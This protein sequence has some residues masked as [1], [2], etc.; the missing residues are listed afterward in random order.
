MDGLLVPRNPAVTMPVNFNNRRRFAYPGG[1]LARRVRPRYNLRSARMFTR[2]ARPSM[3]RIRAG[4]GV[5]DHFDR[6]T[7]YRKKLMPRYKKRR[8]IRFVKKV[9][10]V[11]EKTLGT[12]TIVFNN[13][14]TQEIDYFTGGGVND[15]LQ[16]V[17]YACLYGV[18]SASGSSGDGFLGSKDLQSIYTNSTSSNQA[19]LLCFRSAVLDLTFVNRNYGTDGTTAEN[20]NE[21]LEID[22]YEV[23]VRKNLSYETNPLGLVAAFSYAATQTGAYGSYTKISDLNQRGVTP[24]DL[25]QAMAQFGVKIWK[26][27]KFR[28]QVNQSF[29]YQLRDP[30]SHNIDKDSMD[31]VLGVNMPGITR[32]VLWTAK[33]VAGFT[34]N[35]QFNTSGWTNIFGRLC[36][37]ATRKYSL[38]VNE[39]GAKQDG[40]VTL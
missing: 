22:V 30:R 3:P 19:S 37:G 14:A 7:I 27:T 12:K 2:M 1:S 21:A 40:Y 28:V 8:W 36:V 39:S 25:P 16:I 11:S 26:K 24:F 5:T 33:P 9:Q 17:G 34:L 31:D 35:P 23:T 18:D 29:T 10:A 4:Q 15:N 6:R 13:S 38:V 32:Y 20:W